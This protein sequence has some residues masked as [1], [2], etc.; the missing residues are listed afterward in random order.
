MI[1]FVTLRDFQIQ[2]KKKLPK[3]VY[4]Y[5]RSGADDQITL[6]RNRSDFD[7]IK[8]IPRVL[9]DVSRIDTSVKILGHTMDSPIIIAP[10]AMQKLAH[11]LG[12]IATARAASEV[13]MTAGLSTASTTRLEDFSKEMTDSHAWFQLYV[14]KDRNITR[15]L[16]D[17]AEKAGFK[18]LLVTVDAPVL[19]N[20]ISDHKNHFKV[21]S[22]IHS[23]YFSY[24]NILIL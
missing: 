12:E 10:T 13:K 5:Y 1:K 6:K 11:P 7:K 23:F 21:R 8:L 22:D 15:Q 9:K 19:G 20:R 16:V 14:T 3:M 18:A 2:A 17:R 4:D 24:Q